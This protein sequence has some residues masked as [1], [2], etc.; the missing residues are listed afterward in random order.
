MNIKQL[1]SR[2]I[3]AEDILYQEKKKRDA[4]VDPILKAYGIIR[5]YEVDTIEFNSRDEVEI[6]YTYEDWQDR[7]VGEIT[8]PLA[9]FDAE[10]PVQ[11]AEEAHAVDIAAVVAS[12]A[13]AKIALERHEFER[14]QK[15]FSNS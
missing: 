14:L 11:A 8:I 1:Q 10:D 7:V 4:L 15:K 9:V 2:V 12:Q 3:R 5:G 6:T 13:A